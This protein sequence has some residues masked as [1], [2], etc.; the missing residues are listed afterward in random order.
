MTHIAKNIFVSFAL[1][2]LVIS[3]PVS[4]AHSEEKK[5][6]E[7]TFGF[8]SDG[9]FLI[10]FYVAQKANL[11]QDE[12]IKIDLVRLGSGARIMAAVAGGSVEVA[13]HDF[14]ALIQAASAGADIVVLSSEYNSIPHNVVLSNSAIK[15]SGITENMP[16]LEKLKRMKGLRLGVTG[17]GSGPDRFLRTIYRR[18]NMDPDQMVAITPLGDINGIIAGFQHGT[19]DGF[20]FGAPFPQ[21]AT[22]M[23]LGQI[24]IDPTAGDVPEYSGVPYEVLAA[25]RELVKKNPDVYRKFIRAMT[26]AFKLIEEKPE[27][28]RK[29][30]KEFTPSELTDAAFN[31]GFDQALHGIPTTPVISTESFDKTLDTLSDA[32]GNKLHIKFGNVVDSSI[33]EKAAEE[34]L[35]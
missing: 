23:G 19:V 15:K 20:V 4:R 25:N 18:R 22:T 24:V 21:I 6:V 30:A 9:F 28:A 35:K 31:A 14:G 17:V 5:T 11:F 33:A 8:G 16:L 2:A 12:G 27:E 3:A 26:K 7:V 34:L 10:P 1:T 29:I 13:F 32:E